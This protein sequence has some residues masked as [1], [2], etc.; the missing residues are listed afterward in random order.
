L[1][2]FFE[3]N[4]KKNN[5]LKKSTKKFKNPSKTVVGFHLSPFIKIKKNFF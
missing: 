5:H 2:G 1:E 4:L 3:K